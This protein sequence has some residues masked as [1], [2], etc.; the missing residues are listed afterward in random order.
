MLHADRDRRVGAESRLC[1]PVAVEAQAGTA[2]I[3]GG[4]AGAG[5]K[6][7]DADVTYL[8]PPLCFGK[9]SL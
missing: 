6:V 3:V 5:V 9:G 4:H 8:H 1:Q 7:P 2:G